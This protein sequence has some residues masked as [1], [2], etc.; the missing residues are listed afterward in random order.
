MIYT[1]CGSL[2]LISEGMDGGGILL[3]RVVHSGIKRQYML[4][5]ANFMFYSIKLSVRSPLLSLLCQ[6]NILGCI[7]NKIFEKKLFLTPLRVCPRE[8]QAV[9]LHAISPISMKVCQFKGSTLKL[10]QATWFLFWLFP[11]V[12]TPPLR[13]FLVFPME[14]AS[15]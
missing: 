5:E 13:F 3:Q 14:V 6:C 7:T 8:H 2:V 12:N 4:N 11:W 9:A 15:K 10:K 1:P